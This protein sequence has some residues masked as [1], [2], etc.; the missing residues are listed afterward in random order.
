MSEVA[1]AGGGPNKLFIVLALG[2]VG[3]LVIGIVVFLV[4]MLVI[5]PMTTARPAA[6]TPARAVTITFVTTPTRVALAALTPTTAPPTDTPTVTPTLV[7]QPISGGTTPVSGGA[8]TPTAT[9]TGTVA[10][11]TGTPGTGMPDTGIGED[12][13]LLAGGVVLVFVIV[14]ARRARTPRAA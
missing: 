5:Q 1:P 11:G 7:V 12:L 9:V 2:L 10:A 3:L 4:F 13:L 6:L 8:L 14:A